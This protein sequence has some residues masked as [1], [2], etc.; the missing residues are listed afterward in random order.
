M[1]AQ[2]CGVSASQPMICGKRQTNNYVTIGCRSSHPQL[3]YASWLAELFVLHNDVSLIDMSL[4][5]HN[6]PAPKNPEAVSGQEIEYI[7][8]S[9]CQG[10]NAP[11]GISS[12]SAMLNCHRGWVDNETWRP[13]A[14]ADM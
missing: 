12:A 6:P 4:L 8:N 10:I 5:Y 2:I 1:L 14:A 11:R 13:I 3:F 9:M 7:T